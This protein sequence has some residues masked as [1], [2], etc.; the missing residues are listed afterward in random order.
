VVVEREVVPVLSG[1]IARMRIEDRVR[2]AEFERRARST[3]RV[4]GVRRAAT[5]RRSVRAV[6]ASAIVP[7]RH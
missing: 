1:D 3:R 6:L 4:E 2:E 5:A 7:G